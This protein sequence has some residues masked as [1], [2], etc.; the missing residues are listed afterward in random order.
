MRSLLSRNV[1]TVLTLTIIYEL[2]TLVCGSCCGCFGGGRT[3]EINTIPDCDHDFSANGQQTLFTF[4]PYTI[5]CHWLLSFVI[6]ISI[7]SDVSACA[8]CVCIGGVVNRRTRKVT[9]Y[10]ERNFTVLFDEKHSVRYFRIKEAL[11]KNMVDV[12]KFVAM[13]MAY[14]IV[15]LLDFVGWHLPL[16]HSHSAHTFQSIITYFSEFERGVDKIQ[17]PYR[18]KMGFGIIYSLRHPIPYCTV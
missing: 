11:P 1:V 17:D 4:F 2:A 18:V 3:T 8:C 16:K 14:S 6:L 15:E 9:P 10:P 7:C 5:F 12:G 13:G